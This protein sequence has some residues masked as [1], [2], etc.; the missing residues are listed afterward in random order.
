MHPVQEVPAHQTVTAATKYIESRATRYD[1]A[2]TLA[3]DIEKSLEK[4]FPL[5]VLVQLIEHADRQPWVQLL[6][7][8]P[9]SD[10]SRTAEND[11]AIVRSEER[12]VGKEGGARW[13]EGR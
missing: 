5:T 9:F 10:R 8:Q 3:V 6:E 11:P 7:G 4:G 12:R 13:S 2:H 1:D